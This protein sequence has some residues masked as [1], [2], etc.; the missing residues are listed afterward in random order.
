M[1]ISIC[2]ARLLKQPPIAPM[3][4]H[5]SAVPRKIHRLRPRRIFSIIHKISGSQTAAATIIG[6]TALAIM[7][8]ES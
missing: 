1:V 2:P 5:S 6:K 4:T 3:T 8:P 7:K